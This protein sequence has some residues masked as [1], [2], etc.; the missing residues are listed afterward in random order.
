MIKENQADFLEVYSIGKLL[1]QGTLGEVRVCTHKISQ[2]MRAVRIV[3]KAY[4]DTSLINQLLTQRVLCSTF[5]HPNILNIFETFQDSKRFFIVTEL[6]QGG[7]LFN[8]IE[9]HA[10]AG[11][12]FTEGEAATIVE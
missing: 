5:D 7:E 1:G 6:L 2:Q 8:Q 12:L 10:N 3:K 11:T 4:L 9:N